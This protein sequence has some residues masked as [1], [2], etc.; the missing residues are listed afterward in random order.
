MYTQSF[1][2]AIIAFSAGVLAL[3]A[4]PA[5][6]TTAA[7]PSEGGTLSGLGDAFSSLLGGGGNPVNGAKDIAD[8]G[9]GAIGD[10]GYAVSGGYIDL[11]AALDAAGQIANTPGQLIS[12]AGVGQKGTPA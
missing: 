6:N 5:P 8:I 4:A 1:I 10:A 7:K 3:P 9:V 11:N 12:S 2:I